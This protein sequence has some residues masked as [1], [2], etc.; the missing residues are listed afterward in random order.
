MSELPRG[1]SYYAQGRCIDAAVKTVMFPCEIPK[2]YT[3]LMISLRTAF[4]KD[5]KGFFGILHRIQ[6]ALGYF[7][8]LKEISIERVP[9]QQFYRA[10]L[11]TFREILE[12]KHKKENSPNNSDEALSG[13]ADEWQKKGSDCTEDESFSGTNGNDP[14]DVVA[15]DFS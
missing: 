8:S 2:N 14:N 12:E 6:F 4:L 13:N 11:V 5:E 3:A 10:V 1:I 9:M 7:F 15:D